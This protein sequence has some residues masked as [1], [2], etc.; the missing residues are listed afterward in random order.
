MIRDRKSMRRVIVDIDSL[1]LKGFRYEDR[2]AIKA[3]V[4]EELARV[5]AIPNAAARVAQLGS[6][7]QMHIGNVNVGTNAKPQQVG[8]ATGRAIGQGLIK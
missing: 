6:T 7:P 3:A 8:A 2:H 4:Q 1:V 5:L